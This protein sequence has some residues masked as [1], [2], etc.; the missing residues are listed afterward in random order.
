MIGVVISLV[1]FLLHF[2]EKGTKTVC[3]HL[4]VFLALALTL[5]FASLRSL[6]I[7]F[8]KRLPLLL[9][10]LSR[11]AEKKNPAFSW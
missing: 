4:G 11:V 2:S 3:R 10:I 1:S 6:V 7:S 5:F 9:M 8:E